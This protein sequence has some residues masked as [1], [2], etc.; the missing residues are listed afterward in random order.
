MK[1]KRS[2]ARVAA[3]VVAALAGSAGISYATVRTTAADALI[4]GCYANRLGT[5]RVLEGTAQCTRRETPIWWNQQGPEGPTGPAGPEGP[6]G[7]QGPQGPSGTFNGTFTSPNG[8][9]SITVGDDGIELSG[10]NAGVRIGATEAV[11]SGATARVEALGVAE[12]RGA[13]VMLNGC[14]TP[15]ARV[16][17]RVDA[18]AGVVITGSATVCA[19]G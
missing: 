8:Q 13:V 14:H 15:V 19:G 9:Y 4:R 2:T 16:G 3:V 7:P 18:T 10:P 12:L 5:L 1:P 6:R 17:D 11:V